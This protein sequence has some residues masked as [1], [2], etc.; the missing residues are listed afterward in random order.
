MWHWQSGR[1]SETIKNG[2]QQAMNVPVMM[3]SVLQA[4]RSRRFSA[5][6]FGRRFFFGT[7]LVPLLMA[8]FPKDVYKT[9][10]SAVSPPSPTF[11]WV[12]VDPSSRVSAVAVLSS[13]DVVDDEF[14]LF[15][16]SP[17]PSDEPFFSTS[18]IM[19]AGGRGTYKEPF[20]MFYFGY[21]W[22]CHKIS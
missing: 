14:S 6:S 3:A 12:G 9:H 5:D 7:R 13:S 1:Y 18:Q 19:T 2:V 17:F 8:P 10:F 11:V 15:S 4:L 20:F 22:K 16:R 21:T